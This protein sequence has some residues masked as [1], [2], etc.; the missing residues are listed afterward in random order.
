M[1]R[2]TTS[3]DELGFSLVEVLVVVMIIGILV[4]IALPTFLGAKTKSEDRATQADLR[5]SLAA[6]MTYWAESGT[7]TGLDPATAKAAE[8][9]MDWQPADTSAPGQITIQ[10]ASGPNV[11]L[12]A[13]SKSGTYF[14]MAQ[15]ANNPA[16]DRGRGPT[17]ATVDTVAECTGGW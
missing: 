16:T 5:S 15:V 12:I 11:L 14:C 2:T 3:E 4:A 1:R 8:P 17:F 9:N 13:P 10:V 6:A 7:Y